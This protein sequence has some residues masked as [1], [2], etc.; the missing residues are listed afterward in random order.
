M[1]KIS[2]VL[3]VGQLVDYT[4]CVLLWV[5]QKVK[6]HNRFMAFFNIT[7]FFIKSNGAL[8]YIGRPCINTSKLV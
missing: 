7:F 5:G 4:R 1:E 2:F 3:Y 6:P 8:F